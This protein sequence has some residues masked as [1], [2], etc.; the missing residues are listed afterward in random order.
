MSSDSR[1]HVRGVCR[2]AH[3]CEVASESA[4]ESAKTFARPAATIC[5]ANRVGRVSRYA[6]SKLESLFVGNNLALEIR[7]IL[8]EPLFEFLPLVV[9]ENVV[10]RFPVRRRET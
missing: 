7:H 4:A 2:L 9:V 8:L 5:G 6:L 3:A 10:Q 1:S